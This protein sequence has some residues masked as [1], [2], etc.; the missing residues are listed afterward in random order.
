PMDSISFQCAARIYTASRHQLEVNPNP[1][2]ENITITIPFYNQALGDVYE[3][4]DAQVE[5]AVADAKSNMEFVSKLQKFFAMAEKLCDFKQTLASIAGTIDTVTIWL[6]ITDD[7]LGRAVP[8]VNA[9]RVGLCGKSN[10]FNDLFYNEQKIQKE[11]LKPGGPK[12]KTVS[13]GGFPGFLNKMCAFVNCRAGEEEGMGGVLRT[14]GGDS[15]KACK[16]A[17]NF[18]GKIG[19]VEGFAVTDQQKALHQYDSKYADTSFQDSKKRPATL[20]IKESI[21][22]SSMCLCVPGIIYNLNKLREIE[23]QKALCMKSEVRDKGLPPTVC[24]DLEGYLKCNF[25]VGDVFS[26]FPPARVWSQVTDLLSTV[27]ANPVELFQ[28]Y[29]G[30]VCRGM[31][32]AKADKYLACRI[33]K[34]LSKLGDAIVS[35]TGIGKVKDFRMTPTSGSCDELEDAQ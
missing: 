11:K 18:F 35:F 26:L 32:P 17:K 1:E 30:F 20:N 9:A 16:W 25:I 29:S 10:F 28:L 14:I 24:N 33:P 34:T 3:G 31:C 22:L 21:I 5:A 13:K 19:G 8:G 27:L 4:L 6:G 23:C 15:G 2:V 7:G 12:T